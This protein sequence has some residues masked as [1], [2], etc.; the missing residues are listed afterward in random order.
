MKLSTDTRDVL[1]TILLSM[2]I[3]LVNSG[4]QLATMS[5]MKNI[6]SIATSTRYF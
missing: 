5:Q 3:Y 2:Q 6:V 1:K 4:N